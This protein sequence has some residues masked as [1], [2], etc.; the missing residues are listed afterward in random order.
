MGKSQSA[1]TLLVGKNSWEKAKMKT[2]SVGKSQNENWHYSRD[3]VLL[4]STILGFLNVYLFFGKGQYMC[5]GGRTVVQA[6]LYNVPPNWKN[7]RKK[8][9]PINVLLW[10]L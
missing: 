2:L 10:R 3:S 4:F 6:D 5:W 1:K 7:F 9:Y 8:S